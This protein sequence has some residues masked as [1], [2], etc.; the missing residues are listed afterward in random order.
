MIPVWVIRSALYNVVEFFIL[1]GTYYLIMFQIDCRSLVRELN[2][3]YGWWV[4][5]V[6]YVFNDWN[7]QFV[8]D[9]LNG[10]KL[11]TITEMVSMVFNVA[12]CSLCTY[13]SM[14]PFHFI[15]DVCVCV[16]AVDVE[17]YFPL[18]ISNHDFCPFYFLGPICCSFQNKL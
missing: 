17:K 6:K 18:G 10:V 8:G 1:M 7:F 11:T 2:R 3:V 16:Q 9:K 14:E 15:A 4:V 5:P 12:A 13:F